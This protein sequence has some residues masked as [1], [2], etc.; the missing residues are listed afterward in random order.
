MLNYTENAN[1]VVEKK[2]FTSFHDNMKVFNT[3]GYA[4]DLFSEGRYEA[5]YQQL[6]AMMP[7][8][9]NQDNIARLL[10][11]LYHRWIPRWHFNMLND[12]D[13]I[14]A[15]ANAI[16]TLD[17]E[18]K[19]VLDIGA[20]TGILSM[21]SAKQ[22]A[23]HV[24]ACEAMLPIANVA[25]SIVAKNGCQ[26]NI[27]VIPK[28]SHD[29]QIGKDIPGRIDVLISETIDCGF[30]GEGFLSALAHARQH[31]LK[32]DAICVPQHFLLKGG[33]L[34][35]ETIYHLNRVDTTLG[36]DV[37]DFNKFASKSYFPVRL[38]T[39]PYS[40]LSEINTLIDVDLT[41]AS[42]QP[43]EKT[44]SFAIN[45]TGELHG[46]VF[47]FDVTLVPGIVISNSPQNTRSHW[48]QAFAC[49]DKPKWVKRGEK[50]DLQLTMD[51]E[52]I[53]FTL[54]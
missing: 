41:S 18:N 54:N 30:V 5:C 29:L 10:D 19:T 17:L 47:W 39:W 25:N 12:H 42:F 33:L 32:T 20:G 40:V 3:L 9:E 23:R 50:I 46:V 24:Y 37:S 26:K 1:R 45:Q 15:F 11:K 44:I 21:L 35:S 16:K 53:Q 51:T 8:T 52:T 28:L 31:L 22:G 14:A 13:R 48:M 43:S 6:M 34:S 49:F 27:T 2:I 36:F 7:N 38:N 4:Q